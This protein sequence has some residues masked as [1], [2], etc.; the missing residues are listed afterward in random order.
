MG[1]AKDHQPYL[2]KAIKEGT[3]YIDLWVLYANN[4]SLNTTSK[5]MTYCIGTNIT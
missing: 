3:N 2:Q 4:E 5:L 1:A